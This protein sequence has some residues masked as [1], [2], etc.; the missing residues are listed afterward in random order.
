MGVYN[1]QGDSLQEPESSPMVV[2]A[3][4]GASVPQQGRP[5]PLALRREYCRVPS[6][7]VFNHS[8]FVVGGW[9]PEDPS[10]L[11]EQFCP[12]YNEWR[13]AAPM[14][15]RRGNVAVGTLDGKVYTAG[16][17]DSLRCYSNVERY[18]PH[19]GVWSVEIAPL[20]CPR[21][22][23]C[24]LEMDG[25]LYAMGGSDGITASSTVERYDPKMNTWT[26]QASMLSRRTRAVGA[27]LDGHL[28]VMGGS[29]GT[30]VLNS[31]E[32]YSPEDGSWS[33]CPPMR[34]PR[35]GAGCAVYLGQIYVA[36]GRDE[37]RLDLAAAE[38]LDPD[39]MRWSIVKRMRS[40]RS[41][42]S[43]AVFNG[44]LLAAGGSDGVTNLKTIEAYDPENN[45]WR[46]S[47]E[48]LQKNNSS[49]SGVI[50]DI[51]TLKIAEGDS[52]V[53]PLPPRYRFRDLLLGDQTLQNDDR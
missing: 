45:A 14:V 23:V 17:E 9:T 8:M 48:T 24:L 39:T 47:S 22:G 6:R 29:D 21:S 53:P 34:S 31:V 16:G 38:R 20:S 32:R 19:T 37:L 3:A 4:G 13:V 33:V 50:L 46:S 10:C 18:D 12:E 2:K 43:L 40:K 5:G 15:N 27:V 51:S 42:V 41:N 11:V 26:K 25:Y 44:A 49:N 1:E 28:Y 30:M 36:G 35:E 52:G 7:D